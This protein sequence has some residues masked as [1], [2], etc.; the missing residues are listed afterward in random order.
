M[1]INFIKFHMTRVTLKEFIDLFNNNDMMK[2]SAIRGME[3]LGEWGVAAEYW[4]KIGRDSDAEACRLLE[5]AIDRGDSYRESTKELNDWVDK[6]VC[7][8]IMTKEE[9][10]RVIYP[11]IEE[12]YNRH[13]KSS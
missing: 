5:E 10:V 6:T 4:R 9:A 13:Y 7:E 1:V 8:G 3:Q 11:K 12:L 2:S